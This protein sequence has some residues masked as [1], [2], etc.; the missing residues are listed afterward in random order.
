MLN[1]LERREATVDPRLVAALLAGE[2]R[3]PDEFSD[4]R[5]A[6]SAGDD[7]PMRPL[8]ES[9]TSG[10]AAF[11]H[12][13]LATEIA[14]PLLTAVLRLT[15]TVTLQEAVTEAADEESFGTLTARN[16]AAL[17]RAVEERGYGLSGQSPSIWY[18]PDRP[19]HRVRFARQVVRVEV[20]PPMHQSDHAREWQLD[21]S[22]V[23]GREMDE[24]LAYIDA[25]AQ[26]S[27]G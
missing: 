22:F 9:E 19:D 12:R 17:E 20:R 11:A 26:D 13:F 15:G 6:V 4:L 18:H 2:L 7:S 23:M 27:L 25:L 3:W 21:R 1:I 14:G 10:L 5:T 16:H 8:L 24:F